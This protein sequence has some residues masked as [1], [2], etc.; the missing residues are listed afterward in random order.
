M[1]NSSIKSGPVRVGVAGA[2]GYTGVELVRLLANH[3]YVEIVQ[4]F[5]ESQAGQ[6]MGTL[7]PA[8]SPLTLPILEP[9]S[10]IRWG[11]LD[12]LF[13]CLPHATSQ[14]WAL[15]A[16]DSVRLIDLSADFR[17]KSI[18]TYEK[19]YGPHYAPELQAKAVYGLTEYNRKNIVSARLVACPGCY[20]TCST[21][22]L[23]PLLQAGY[24][25]GDCGI[26]IDA[27][28]GVSGAGRSAK[29]PQLFCEVADNIRVYNVNNHRH[30]PEIEQLC[31]EVSGQNIRVDFI[32]HVVPMSRGMIAT[33]MV[34]LASGVTV[35][36]ARQAIQDAYHDEPYVTC[37]PEGEYPSTQAVVGSNRCQIGLFAGQAGTRLLLIS[38]IDNLLKGASGQAIQN[39][40]VMYQWP[41]TTGLPLIGSYP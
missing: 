9:L 35:T 13:L 27:K 33:V 32:P 25:N 29:I 7:F 14:K 37:L 15:Q 18:E 23:L 24:V 12:V 4:L 40:N 41:E 20:P 1:M 31:S 16:P 34:Q 10:H 28:S 39:L 36:M 17:L 26:I 22:P 30:I 2:S 3:P 11:D 8:L 38:V 6:Q 5:A 19:W 21:L